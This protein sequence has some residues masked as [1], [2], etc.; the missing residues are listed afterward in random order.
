MADGRIP[1]R[2]RAKVSLHARRRCEYCRTPESYSPIPRHS[3][4]HIIPVCDGGKT[5]F[6]NLALSCQGCNSL[7][8]RRT[9]AVSL[10]TGLAV[11][12]FHPRQD[13][14]RDHFA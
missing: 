10:Q 2:L 3:I 12:L 11:R 7:K 5:Q 13:R 8:S 14:W 6:K 9:V 1:E 4:D